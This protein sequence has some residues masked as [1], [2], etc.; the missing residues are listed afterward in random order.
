MPGSIRS[1]NMFFVHDRFDG[2][3]N[4]FS[5]YSLIDELLVNHSYYEIGVTNKSKTL[6][7][8]KQTV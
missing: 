6:D 3:W 8:V 2:R 7:C 1:V 5:D 4:L